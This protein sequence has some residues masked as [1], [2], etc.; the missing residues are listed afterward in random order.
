VADAIHNGLLI[1]PWRE[2]EPAEFGYHLVYRKDLEHRPSIRRVVDW[3]C[4][5]ARAFN[6]T[7]G[8]ASSAA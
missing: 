3:L 6:A 5:E 1:R 8:S 7:A 4:A 2:S